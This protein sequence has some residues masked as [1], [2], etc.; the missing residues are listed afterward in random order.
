MAT[1]CTTHVFRL[2][3][4]AVDSGCII[5]KTIRSSM[6]L[7]EGVKL[8]QEA[9]ELHQ[10]G[11]HR[12]RGTPTGMLVAR[13]DEGGEDVQAK[14][15]GIKVGMAE[16]R[17]LLHRKVEHRRRCGIICGEDDPHMERHSGKGPRVWSEVSMPLEDVV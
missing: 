12:V 4:N 1:R 7:R 14:P 16:G 5:S 2:Q 9:L 10:Q 6:V 3:T 15:E 13:P 8:E 11:P 17:D